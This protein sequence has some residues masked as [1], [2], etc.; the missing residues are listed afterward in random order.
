MIDGDFKI[1]SY[2]LKLADYCPEY[3]A[4]DFVTI[5]VELSSE[6]GLTEY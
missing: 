2:S 3:Q 1:P 5:T 4:E 6:K